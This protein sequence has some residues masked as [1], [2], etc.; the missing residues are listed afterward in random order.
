MPKKTSR[1]A[2]HPTSQ[3]ARFVKYKYTAPPRAQS[4][5]ATQDVSY[6]G[7]HLAQDRGGETLKS[8]SFLN[9]LRLLAEVLQSEDIGE[10]PEQGYGLQGPTS[11][12][13]GCNRCF[14]AESIGH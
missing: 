13:I 11:C 12:S 7:N 10:A 14:I 1:C 9:P 4:L 2:L 8:R 5:H 3:A 6:E